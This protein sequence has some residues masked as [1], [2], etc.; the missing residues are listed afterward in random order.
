MKIYN[1]IADWFHLLTHPSDYADEAADYVRLIRE[2]QPGARTLLELGAGG[3]NN[4]SHMK[5]HFTCTLTDLSPRMLEVSRSINPECEHI[6]GDMRELRLE[7]QF[8]VVFVHDAV[9]YMTTL[10]DLSRAVR[11]AYV[12]AR[13]GGLAL[14]VPDG[15]RETF[16]ESADHGGH[17]GP[18]GRA[19]RYLEWTIDLDPADT[20]YEVHFACLLR[21]GDTV[22]LVHDRH[23]HALFTR[24]QWREVLEGAGFEV[25]VAPLEREREKGEFPS[26]SL[27]ASR[28]AEEIGERRANVCGTLEVGEVPAVLH[29]NQPGLRNRARDV[30]RYLGGD[31]VIVAPDDQRRHAQACQTG[32]QIV[33]LDLPGVVRQLVFHRSRLEDPCLA[34]ADE[35]R[36]HRR[37]QLL[38]VCG[39][40]QRRLEM[41]P[42]PGGD[43][44]GVALLV[45]CALRDGALSIHVGGAELPEVVLAQ[46]REV[47]S[48]GRCGI[49]QDQM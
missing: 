34:L 12:H 28:T 7:R 39:T 1:E 16:V 20:F 31:E 17:D 49:H 27:L 22:R 18:D 23:Q 47:G 29:R 11:T 13:P 46:H 2:A 33:P 6:Q 35:S 40:L 8:D 4:A 32:M 9:E 41:E 25:T 30:C 37:H 45:G 26:P 19:M 43:R 5:R 36:F 38:V 44:L 48:R 3:G 21:E 42:I 14:F 10:D 24:Q 15:T